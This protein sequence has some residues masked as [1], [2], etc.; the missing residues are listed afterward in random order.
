MLAATL[1]NSSAM[2][3]ASSM[4]RCSV[5]DQLM[6]SSSKCVFQ[7]DLVLGL[8]PFA[9]MLLEADMGVQPIQLHVVELPRL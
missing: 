6:P 8:L 2:L 1:Q 3:R 4:A 7:P 5:P 9:E